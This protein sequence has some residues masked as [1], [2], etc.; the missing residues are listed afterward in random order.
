MYPHRFFRDHRGYPK[1]YRVGVA[2]RCNIPLFA[3]FTAGA[4]VGAELQLMQASGL[5]EVLAWVLL[6]CSL[7]VVLNVRGGSLRESVA[8]FL[9]RAEQRVAKVRGVDTPLWSNRFQYTTLYGEDEI[10]AATRALLRK[11]IRAD[12][13]ERL[14]DYP[15]WDS[16]WV[17][18]ALRSS[19]NPG[20]ARSRA[21]LPARFAIPPA[22]SVSVPAAAVI[23]PRPAPISRAASGNPLAP[24]PYERV[25][26]P[27]R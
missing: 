19:A 16:A 5:W 8:L 14:A 2:T 1:G 18:P 10:T 4:A 23:G 20:C 3:R 21:A 24:I 7:D 11:P 26:V 25:A 17:A 9:P 22:P 6:P 15:F 27:V 13:V 12:L